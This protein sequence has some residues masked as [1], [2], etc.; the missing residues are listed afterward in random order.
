MRITREEQAEEGQEQGRA[1]ARC[2]YR[3]TAG[4]K[5]VFT[6]QTTTTTVMDRS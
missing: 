2:I 3:R 6:A 5:A 4:G 1:A